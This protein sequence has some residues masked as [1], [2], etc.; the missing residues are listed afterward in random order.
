MLLWLAA[1]GRR[2]ESFG[3]CSFPSVYAKVVALSFHNDPVGVCMVSIVALKVVRTSPG[4][5]AWFTGEVTVMHTSLVSREGQVS[6]ASKCSEHSKTGQAESQAESIALDHRNASK[7][8]VHYCSDAPR[9][10][11]RDQFMH[12][13]CKRVSWQ[14]HSV[15]KEKRPISM[16]TLS[17]MSAP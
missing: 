11:C 10:G 12:W 1:I 17:L 6:A 3:T 5:L 16:G 14:P 2:N 8:E 15:A 4:L 13:T 7:F 9:P